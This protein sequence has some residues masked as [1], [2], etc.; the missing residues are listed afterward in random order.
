MDIKNACNSFLNGIQVAEALIQTGQYRR[1]LV[2][3][4]EMPSRG[5]KWQVEDFADL[6][7]SFLGYTLGDAGVAA[8]LEPA[9]A[10]GQGIFY[11]KFVAVSRHWPACTILGG[12]SM[13]PRDPA[14]TYTQGDGL[15]LKNAFAELGPQPVLQALAETELGFADFA[16]ILIHQVSLASLRELLALLQI[17]EAQV[18]LTVP[19]YGNMAAASI[20]VAFDLAESRG[21]IRRGDRVLLIGLA[22]GISVGVIMFKY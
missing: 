2:T 10:D 12:G 16:R 19:E 3:G 14:Y 17:P 9:D 1:V 20:P 11:R 21:E 8:L 15:A 13:H 7:Q 22:A 6:R 18:V 4:G 5:I